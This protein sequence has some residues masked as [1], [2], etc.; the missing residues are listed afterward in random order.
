MTATASVRSS[1]VAAVTVMKP[2][3]SQSACPAARDWSRW[4]TSW[5]ARRSAAPGDL[6]D[7][8]FLFGVG[9]VFGDFVLDVGLG[10]VGG[11]GGDDEGEV[12]AYRVTGAVVGEYDGVEEVA[13]LFGAGP[14]GDPQ[15]G[16]VAAVVADVVP[17]FVDGDGPG[18]GRGGGGGVAAGLLVG[19]VGVADEGGQ[20]GLVEPVVDSQ[21]ASGAEGVFEG[22]QVAAA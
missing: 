7:A 13:A 9:D 5:W 22:G 16:G 8:G 15:G 6:A 19:V 14:F 17:V 2:K 11:Q 18:A 3:Y 21:F 12:F 1:W 20:L 4:R 10:D